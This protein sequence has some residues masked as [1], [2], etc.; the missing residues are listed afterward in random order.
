MVRILLYIHAAFSEEV[1]QKSLL[2]QKTSRPVRNDSIG[3]NASAIHLE[4]NK[5]VTKLQS[6]YGG[7]KAAGV[8]TLEITK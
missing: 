8:G 4:T 1:S 5:A 7:T 2:Y 6:H 3:Q